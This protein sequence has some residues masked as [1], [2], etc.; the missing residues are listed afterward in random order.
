MLCLKSLMIALIVFPCSEK[1]ECNYQSATY[2]QV[3]KGL[4]FFYSR[5]LFIDGPITKLS[6]DWCDCIH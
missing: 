5:I 1:A 2:E 6:S 3:E 4:L